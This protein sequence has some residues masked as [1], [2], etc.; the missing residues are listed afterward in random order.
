MRKE[1]VYFFKAWCNSLLGLQVVVYTRFLCPNPST[2]LSVPKHKT[3]YC[4]CCFTIR[5]E[6][7]SVLENK[8]NLLRFFSLVF[9]Y[10]ALHI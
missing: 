7:E 9:N 1:G 6:G 5:L 3:N 4:E 8:T 2:S 10:Y